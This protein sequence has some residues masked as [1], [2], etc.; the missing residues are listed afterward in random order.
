MTGARRAGLVTSVCTGSLLLAAS[1]LL[2]GKRA[3]SHWAVRDLLKNFGA[4]PVDERV[5]TDGKVITGAGVSAGLDFAV[6]VVEKLRGRGYAQMMMLVG[7]Y[8]PHPPIPGG[9]V[10]QTPRAISEPLKAMFD[11][12]A[13]DVQRLATSLNFPG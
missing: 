6:T 1:G 10:A 11:P 3:T 8:A 12:I 5:V 13:V 7:E 4:Q 9:T 2:R